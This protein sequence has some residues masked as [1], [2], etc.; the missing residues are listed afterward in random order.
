M[1]FIEHKEV[2]IENQKQNT[3]DNPFEVRCVFGSYK[4]LHRIS[5]KLVSIFS[6]DCESKRVNVE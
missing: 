2:S 3:N 6:V 1:K 5:Y 4:T